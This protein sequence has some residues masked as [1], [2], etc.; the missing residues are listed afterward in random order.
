MA[1]AASS[2]SSCSRGRMWASTTARAFDPS[3]LQTATVPGATQ[4][5]GGVSFEIM[6]PR[7]EELFAALRAGAPFPD[8]LTQPEAGASPSEA[9][10]A[11]G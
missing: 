3:T 8:D 1:K 6:Q 10:A 4:L 2:L 11:A 5:Q 9:P 7:A